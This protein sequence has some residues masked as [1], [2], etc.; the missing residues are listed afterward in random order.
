[1]KPF[2]LEASEKRLMRHHPTIGAHIIE[3]IDSEHRI[4]RGIAQHHEWF[5]GKGYPNGLK[6]AQISP[7]GRIIAVADAFDALTT[8]RPYKKAFSPKGA[9]FEIRKSSGRQFD[10]K[11]VKAFILSFSKHPSVWQDRSA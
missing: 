7:E 4:A 1:M 10:P 11:V 9:F 3:S 5:N 6:G 8:K 2:R